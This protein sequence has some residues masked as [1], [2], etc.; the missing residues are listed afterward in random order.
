MEMRAFNG[1]GLLG[2]YATMLGDLSGGHSIKLYDYPSLPIVRTLG[3]EVHRQWD[4]PEGTVAELKPVVPFWIDVDIKYD[5]GTNLAWR[6]NDGIWKDSSGVPFDAKP[7][8]TPPPPPQFNSTITTAIDE[9]AGPFEYSN[10]TVRVLPLLAQR[11]KLQKYVDNFLNVPLSTPMK[12]LDGKDEQVQFKVWARNSVDLPNAGPGSDLAYVYLNVTTFDSII[13]LTNNIGNW[14]KYQLSFMIPVE[15]QR[16]N[17]AGGWDLAGVG[18]VPAFSFADNCIAAIARLEVEGFEASVANFSRPESVWLSNQDEFRHDPMQTLLRVDAEVMSALGQSQK[19]VVQPVIEIIQG[20]PNAGLGTSSDPPWRWSETLRDELRAKKSLKADKSVDLQIGRALA[21]ELLGNQMP[22]NAYSMKQFRD[23]ADPARACYQSLVRVPRLIKELCDVREIEDTLVVKIHDYPTLNIV[24]QL[25][26]VAT[27]LPAGAMGIVSTVQ[28]VR[29]F[30]VVGT[31][32]EPLAERL[33][34][35]SP[36]A[37]WVLD[38]EVAFST[39]LSDQK[40]APPI[41][42]DFLA[43]ALQD[44]MD[45][46]H[47][48]EIMYQAAQRRG[49]DAAQ[50]DELQAP[51]IG[52]E[53]ARR[54]L[55]NIDAQS[56][57]ESML[58]REWGNSDDDTRWRAGRQELMKALSALPVSGEMSAFA[59]TVLYRQLNNQLAINPGAV[60]SPLKDVAEYHKDLTGTIDRLAKQ[61]PANAAQRWR[62][63]IERII[64]MQEQFTRLGMEMDSCINLL[65]AVAILQ[66]ADLSRCYADLGQPAPSKDEIVK[67]VLKLNQTLR[68]ISEQQI[69]GEPSERNNLDAGVRADQK[70]LQDLLKAVPKGSTTETTLPKA[71]DTPDHILEWSMQHIDEYRNLVALARGFCDVQTEALLNKLSRA[72]QKPDF[73]I[74][75]DSVGT[76]SDELLPLSLSWDEDWYYGRDAERLQRKPAAPK[77]AAASGGK[78]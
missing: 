28:A 52:K 56:V 43:E 32:Q 65:A 69:V 38:G 15:F 30:F 21:L 7:S 64:L 78:K 75:R 50:R 73:C 2:E 6:T 5:A 49:L 33:G 41:T 27:T 42:A 10:A 4:G 35:R 13:S 46:C 53:Q 66:P 31:L 17:A 59:Q 58:S 14:T 24:D 44:Q 72:Y 70:R 55:G 61:T 1:G 74:R 39:L 37:D 54:A 8:A 67:V 47:I 20:D 36:G 45:P 16:R 18:L 57:I 12:G 77:P 63:Q 23:V 25:G 3:L 9:I 76:N 48:S 62:N 34:W 29:P 19:A 11:A 51:A 60:A 40:G 71:S 22:V 68:S 26:L